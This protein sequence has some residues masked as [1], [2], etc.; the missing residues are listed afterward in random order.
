MRRKDP[1]PFLLPSL[2]RSEVPIVWGQGRRPVL[3]ASV[4]FGPGGSSRQS[5]QSLFLDAHSSSLGSRPRRVRGRR[6][7]VLKLRKDSRRRG[8]QSYFYSFPSP[9]GMR[10]SPPI[11]VLPRTEPRWGPRWTDREEVRIGSSPHT[12]GPDRESDVQRGGGTPVKTNTD[13]V[14]DGVTCY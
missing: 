2:S 9:T 3:S 13:P 5:V 11:P 4:L 10:R 12:F 6:R 1:T 8:T 7:T 14:G